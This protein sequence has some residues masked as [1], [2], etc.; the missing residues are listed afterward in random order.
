MGGG[1]YR[2][3]GEESGEAGVGAWPAGSTILVTGGSGFVGKA[4]LNALL[5]ETEGARVRVLLRSRDQGNAQRRLVEEILGAAPF[6]L[7]PPTTVER[8]LREREIEA[9]CGDLGDDGVAASA[10]E[11][12]GGIDT[13]IHCAASVSFEEPLDAALR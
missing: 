4:V 11:Q 3:G 13:V 7:V 1:V 2:V 12:L 10:R 5:G 8:M 6:H 9:I